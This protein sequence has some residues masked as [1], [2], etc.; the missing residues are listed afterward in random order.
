MRPPPVADLGDRDSASLFNEREADQPVLERAHLRRRVTPRTSS[1]S[2]LRHPAGGLA[3]HGIEL[4]HASAHEV[5]QR[6]D[7]AIAPGVVEKSMPTTTGGESSGARL[8]QIVVTTH[9]AASA[10]SPQ[11]EVEPRHGGG[12]HDE[13][14][15]DI[16]T[17]S[18]H[19]ESEPIR[20]L[21]ATERLP[22]DCAPHPGS[23]A[24]PRRRRAR[25][26]QRRG[27]AR[28]RSPLRSGAAARTRR[29]RGQPLRWWFERDPAPTRAASNSPSD[30]SPAAAQM[31][32]W[33]A[34]THE[35][36]YH[37]PMKV[38]VFGATGRTGLLLAQVRA[39]AVTS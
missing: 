34:A 3:G 31:S 24:D 20:S 15:H 5:E 28:P 39:S 26:V 22:R 14:R 29:D 27:A 35:G 7:H 10:W 8:T 37:G 25:L 9:T 38:V 4:D 1:V 11:Q 18:S 13:H 2:S 16:A 17:A 21:H 36:G 12:G 30:R 23:L 6:S 32:W 19:Q 33:S